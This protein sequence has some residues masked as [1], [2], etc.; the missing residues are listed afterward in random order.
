MLY[1][2]YWLHIN[3]SIWFTAQFSMGGGDQA[4]IQ[5][6]YWLYYD[7]TEDVILRSHFFKVP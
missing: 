2:L 6:R 3:T 4:E 7:W 5:T 1:V